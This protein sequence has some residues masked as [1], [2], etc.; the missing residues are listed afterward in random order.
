MR[1]EGLTD[2]SL[3]RYLTDVTAILNGAVKRRPPLLA[4]NPVR[5][6]KKPHP[7]DAIIIPPSDEEIAALAID[8]KG[9][10]LGQE[11]CGNQAE[12]AA[13]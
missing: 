12:A 13:L 2:S 10:V 11:E 7:D 6:Y 5:D 1:K 3:R 9:L 4:F 8:Q